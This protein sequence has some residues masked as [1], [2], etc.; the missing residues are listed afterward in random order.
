MTVL[1]YLVPAALTL[2]L[3]GL[4]A[5]MWSLKAGQYDDMEGAAVRV[6]AD[7]DLRDGDVHGRA[8]PVRTARDRGARAGDVRR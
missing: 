4:V 1:L 2:G 8:A 5:F 7:D 3:L 6:L